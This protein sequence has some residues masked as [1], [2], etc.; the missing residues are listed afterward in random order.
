MKFKFSMQKVLETRKLRESLQQREFQE[1]VQF[2]NQENEQLQ[3]MIDRVAQA[4]QRAGLLS[5]TGGHQ[6][7]ALT[8]IHDFLKGQEILIHRQQQKIQETQ[9]LV[10]AK[11]ELL[12]QAS[13]DYKIIDKMRER[14]FE[15]YRRESLIEDQKESDEQSILRHKV[16]ER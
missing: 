11:R 14:K 12:R 6:G 3:K 5:Q 8:Q 1:A 10:E 15:E 7:P 2:L 4:H 13:I 16:K 9:K